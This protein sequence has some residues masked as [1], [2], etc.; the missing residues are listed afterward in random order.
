MVKPSPGEGLRGVFEPYALELGLL[1]YAWNHLQD[2]LAR[3]FSLMFGV[4]NDM[5]ALAVWHSTPSD[6]AQRKMLKAAAEVQLVKDIR[7]RDDILWLLD[8]VDHML[9][10]KRNN[11]IH[12]AVVIQTGFEGAKIVPYE[13]AKNPRAAALKDKDIIKELV[14]Y[15]DTAVA[16]RKFSSALFRA[17]GSAYDEPWP[18]RPVLPHLGQKTTATG[19]PPAKPRKE[20]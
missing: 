11:A 2:D 9:S 5:A 3:L 12:A 17:L 18:D 15:R 13:M 19:K 14:W 6:L 8:K 16:L 7:A 20:R 4:G 1:V 10:G